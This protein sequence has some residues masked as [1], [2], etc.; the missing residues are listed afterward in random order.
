MHSISITST[1]VAEVKDW[2]MD[3][4]VWQHNLVKL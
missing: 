2:H 4:K 1:V 3:D